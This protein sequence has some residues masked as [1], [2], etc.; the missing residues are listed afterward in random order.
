M[1][2]MG[3]SPPQPGYSDRGSPALVPTPAWAVPFSPNPPEPPRT[4]PGSLLFKQ[5]IKQL[6]CA[7]HCTGIEALTHNCNRQRDTELRNAMM[8]EYKGTVDE[9]EGGRGDGRLPKE[10]VA[11]LP[12]PLTPRQVRSGKK[13]SGRHQGWHM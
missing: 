8:G 13:R 9:E 1:S 2:V 7:S 4:G 12:T 3:S 10:G 11:A 5:F 6:L